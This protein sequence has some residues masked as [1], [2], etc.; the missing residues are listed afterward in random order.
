M[1]T[2]LQGLQPWRDEGLLA[3]L[4]QEQMDQTDGSPTEIKS[5]F[6]LEKPLQLELCT[7]RKYF[8]RH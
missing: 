1:G 3:S 6:L 2:T 5:F 4:L 7:I 8:T